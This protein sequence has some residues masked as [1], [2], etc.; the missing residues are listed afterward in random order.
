MGVPVNLSNSEDMEKLLLLLLTTLLLAG[1]S[2]SENSVT[3]VTDVG[4]TGETEDL[5]TVT[6]SIPQQ[7][8]IL[9][10]PDSSDKIKPQNIEKCDKCL[11]LTFRYRHTGFCGKCVKNNYIDL[12]E[13]QQLSEAQHCSKCR[14]T[15]FRSRYQLFCANNCPSALEEQ[16]VE[17]TEVPEEPEYTYRAETKTHRR[18]MKMKAREE[19]RKER[20]T[21][22]MEKNKKK[23]PPVADLGPLGN[24]LKA[25]IEA[26][27]WTWNKSSHHSFIAK[28]DI[29]FSNL[30]SLYMI[31]K[32]C[33]I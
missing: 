24:I 32:Y 31:Y 2:R 22:R 23:S 27:T 21:R 29:S 20:E 7:D 3:G 8:V 16:T 19:R 30:H 5:V 15:K 18:A 10:L 13:Q 9:T 11:K 17:A 28:V 26:N 12:E 14:K 1:V 4:V 25:I 6:T 33:T